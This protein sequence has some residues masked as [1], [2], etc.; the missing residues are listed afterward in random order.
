MHPISCHNPSPTKGVAPGPRHRR[1]LCARRSTPHANLAPDA[2][3]ILA[4][5]G[6][7]GHS[8]DDH[9]AEPWTLNRYPPTGMPRTTNHPSYRP[10]LPNSITHPENSSCRCATIRASALC[11]ANVREQGL[12]PTPSVY[13]RTPNPSGAPLAPRSDEARAQKTCPVHGLLHLQRARSR[14][15]VSPNR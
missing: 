4:P 11:P 12:D 1:P 5:A 3:D 9:A 8:T 15:R 13:H 7:R 14:R 6:K 10:G 2:T